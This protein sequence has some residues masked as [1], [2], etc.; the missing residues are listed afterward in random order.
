[1]DIH[2]AIL[3]AQQSEDATSPY[4]AFAYFFEAEADAVGNT[5]DSNTPKNYTAVA[6]LSGNSHSWTCSG[7]NGPFQAVGVANGHDAF[8]FAGTQ[9]NGTLNGVTAMRGFV[10]NRTVTGFAMVANFNTTATKNLI[11]RVLGPSGNKFVLVV[12]TDRTIE[13]VARRLTADSDLSFK[14]V[15]LLPT[16]A[17]W[18]F[19]FIEL[20]WLT[21]QCTFGIDNQPDEIITHL[22]GW[23][24]APGFGRTTDSDSS[25]NPTF[26]YVSAGN[27]LNAN[28][29]WI[30]GWNGK[31]PAATRAALFA[32]KQA[33]Y[34]TVLNTLVI[35]DRPSGRYGQVWQRK[36]AGGHDAIPLRVQTAAGFSDSGDILVKLIDAT[37]RATAVDWAALGTMTGGDSTFNYDFPDGAYKAL[38]KRDGEVDACAVEGSETIRIGDRTIVFASDSIGRDLN[39]TISAAARPY[40]SS[41]SPYIATPLSATHVIRRNRRF[42]WDQHY[43]VTQ[44]LF[45][46]YLGTGTNEPNSSDGPTWRDCGGN[47]LVL[48]CYNYNSIKG[49]PVEVMFFPVG[50]TSIFDWAGPS[51]TYYDRMKTLLDG[52]VENPGPGWDCKRLVSIIGGTDMVTPGRTQTELEDAWLLAFNSVRAEYEAETGKT[53]SDLHCQ[54]G[55]LGQRGSSAGDDLADLVRDAQRNLPNR[56]AN[57]QLVAVHNDLPTKSSIDPHYEVAQSVIFGAD[58][59]LQDTLFWDGDVANDA[60]GPH[61]TAETIATGADDLYVDFSLNGGTSLCDAALATTGSGFTAF[62]IKLV[63]GGVTTLYED[64]AAEIVDSNTMKLTVPGLAADPADTITWR[65]AGGMQWDVTK[66]LY[67]NFAFL[68]QTKAPLMS[69]GW[70]PVA[71]T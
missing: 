27:T 65:Y 68:G 59:L 66:P 29:A 51:T 26:G 10:R 57:I 1:M 56:D 22:E 16:A 34:N 63:R 30:A 11:L 37:T 6:D 54:V 4:G 19:L 8:G 14:T 62:D 9:A 39:D 18:Q 15:R 46:S 20:D 71:I 40:L 36:P 23:A 21:G 7:V 44:R 50:G 38:Y 28:V 3:S 32:A 17:A 55:L 35:P 61:P 53:G 12:N 41:G 69:T 2:P 52:T 13:L 60:T 25:T 33:K 5:L 58:R 24:T 31:M 43:L 70:R 64:V 42:S 67:A 49:Y 47:A 45:N 48:Y